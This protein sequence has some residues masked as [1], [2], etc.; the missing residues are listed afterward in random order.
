[1]DKHAARILTKVWKHS[2]IDGNVWTPKIAN[3]GKKNQKFFEGAAISATSGKVPKTDTDHDWYW[4]PAVSTGGRKAE[5]FP[6]Q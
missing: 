1:M 4:T 2:E 6:A 5:D 3:I